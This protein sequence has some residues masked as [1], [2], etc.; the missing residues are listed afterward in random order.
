MQKFCIVENYGVVPLL[1][2]YLHTLST[3]YSYALRFRKFQ[4]EVQCS[5][6]GVYIWQS[7]S[8]WLREAGGIAI[9]ER[10]CCILICLAN[11]STF[12]LWTWSLWVICAPTF[13][14]K[15]GNAGHS[16]VFEVMFFTKSY[17]RKKQRWKKWT[18]GR[19]LQEALCIWRSPTMRE[20]KMADRR[21]RSQLKLLLLDVAWQCSHYSLLGPCGN[22]L[23]ESFITCLRNKAHAYY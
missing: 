6:M 2:S 15:I 4:V 18:T 17:K 10:N 11:S 3:K 23:A 7:T 16:G 12:G 1:A 19:L 9:R 22:S 5:Q 8:S 14:Q 13:N 21:I 20:F